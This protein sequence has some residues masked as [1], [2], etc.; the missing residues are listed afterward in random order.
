[1]VIVPVIYWGGD[2]LYRVLGLTVI[3][4]ALACLIIGIITPMLEISAFNTNLT[5]P[6]ELSLPWIRKIDIPDKV[7]EGRMYYYYQSKSVVDLINVL[8][9]SKNY[10]VAASIISFSVLVPT[11]KLALS[12]LLLL[13][14][15]FR[16]CRFVKKTVNTIGKW[17]MADVFIAATFL[18]YLSFSNMNPGIETE[19]KTLVGLYFFLSYCILSLASSQFV[20]FELK[21]NK[22]SF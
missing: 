2:N 14:R 6:L 3:T 17:S 11:I 5:I 21:K 8:F 13:S 19:V 10:V 9:E 18:S 1:M 16:D 15:H 12:V 20:E 7:F 4:I 22:S